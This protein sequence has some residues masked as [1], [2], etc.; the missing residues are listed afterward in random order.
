MSYDE[1]SI[2]DKIS[3]KGILQ[4]WAKFGVERFQQSLDK[5]VYRAS[6]YGIRRTRSG[7]RYTSI[8]RGQQQLRNNWWRNASDS[9]VVLEFLQYGRYVDMGV[10]KYTSHTDR[11]VSRQLREGSPGRKRRAWYSK[12]KTHQIKRLREI[13][14]EHGV[15]LPLDFVENALTLSLTRHF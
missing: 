11:L 7:A 3:F 8:N 12:T 1:L 15:R 9:G 14:A 10:G 2:N 6:T 5:K 4:D 13:M